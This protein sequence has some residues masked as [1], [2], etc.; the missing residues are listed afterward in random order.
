[1]V[2]LGEGVAGIGC[3]FHQLFGLF[4]VRFDIFAL[5]QHD[6]IFEL[7][8]RIS[9]LGCLSVPER[10]IIHAARNPQTGGEQ[11][12]QQ[13]LR[14]RIPELRARQCEFHGSQIVAALKC[15][16]GLLHRIDGLRPAVGGS[17]RCSFCR[18]GCGVGDV[19][20]SCGLHRWGCVLG[21]RGRRGQCKRGRHNNGR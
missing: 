20:F 7:R 1:M 14:R 6:A 17:A 5:K 11:L 21:S 9:A 2:E 13:C 18:L 15:P 10:C 12:G 4:A 16:E 19:R 3:L 8:R